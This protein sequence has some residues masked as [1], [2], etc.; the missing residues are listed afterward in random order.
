MTKVKTKFGIVDQFDIYGNHDNSVVTFESNR[1]EYKIIEHITSKTCE[2]QIV[3]IFDH[4]TNVI[5]KN[6]IYISGDR[7]EF[8]QF[9]DTETQVYKDQADLIS[10]MDTSGEDY[11]RRIT[12]QTTSNITKWTD[13]KNDDP[14]I[15]IIYDKGSEV[16]LISK[17]VV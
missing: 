12:F 9:V 7:E 17:E 5:T 14:T 2:Y 16:I 13:K 3:L 1:D 10:E 11:A 6:Y 8:D 4:A 15:D